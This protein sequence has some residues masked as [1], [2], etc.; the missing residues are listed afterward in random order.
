MACRPTIA[1]CLQGTISTAAE[2]GGFSGSPWTQLVAAAAQP[3]GSLGTA[4]QPGASAEEQRA[5]VLKQVVF[6]L[7]FCPQVMLL[8]YKLGSESFAWQV[9][10]FF[11]L[12]LPLHLLCDL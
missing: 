10:F 2:L 9:L 4:A 7:T 1:S 8:T 6:V 12:L 5:A 11:F 3:G